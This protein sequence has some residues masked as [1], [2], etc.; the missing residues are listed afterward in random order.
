VIPLEWPL[1]AV[2]DPNTK[3]RNENFMKP[4]TESVTHKT[5]S[6]PV[7]PR[8]AQVASTCDFHRSFV[9]WRIDAEKKDALT[10]SHKPPFRVNNVRIPLECRATLIDHATGDQTAH[11]ALTASCKTEHVNVTGD[12]WTQPNADLAVIATDGRFLGIKTWDKADKGVMRYPESLGVQPERQIENAGEAFDSFSVDLHYRS[13][14][15][16]TTIDDTIETLSGNQEVIARTIIVHGQYE[17]IIEYPIKTINFSERDRY[18]QVDTG[19]I[20]FPD[21]DACDGGDMLQS[22]RLAYV[23]H[24][25]D[26]WA[27]F[28]LNVPTPL[29]DGIS[30]HHYSKSVRLDVHN[31]LYR[32]I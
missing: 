14:I 21:F 10:V 6:E 15:E 30:V 28:L 25:C 32:V 20:L 2:V 24:N 23:S 9:R 1:Q 5:Q 17:F 11:Y 8:V 26:S 12:I 4:L 31:Q 18:Y 13:A 16:L 22:L 7:E 27:E 3:N 29:T 19:P